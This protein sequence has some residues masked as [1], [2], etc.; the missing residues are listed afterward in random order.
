M[1]HRTLI[2]RA[3]LVSFA[4]IT[5]SQ[6]LAAD[7]NT[8]LDGT[9]KDSAG[10]PV[11]HAAVVLQDASG[12]QAGQTTTDAAGHFELLH[13]PTGTY[14]VTVTAPGFAAASQIATTAPASPANVAV[15]LSKGGTLDVQVNARRLNEARNGLLPETGSSIYRITQADIQA[16]PQG[17]NTPLNQVLLQ[18]PGVADDSYGQLHVRGDHADLQYRING[19]PSRSAVSGNRSIRA[20]S[21]R[22]I[23]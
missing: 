1:I 21:T 7:A 4:M 6:A 8:T 12:A 18:A 22:S 5:A 16:M 9:V 11:D 10:K 3:A 2:A 17:Q 14:A 13:V 23:S 20:S 19:I 15:V